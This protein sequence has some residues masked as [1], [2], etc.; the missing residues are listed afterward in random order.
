MTD[1]SDYSPYSVADDM[2]WAALK[3]TTTTY[4]AKLDTWRRQLNPR[5]NRGMDFDTAEMPDEPDERHSPAL[6]VLN[7]AIDEEDRTFSTVKRKYRLEIVG[8]IHVSK[9]LERRADRLIKRYQHLVELCLGEAHRELVLGNS[10]YL[11]TGET[12]PIESIDPGTPEFPDWR[13]DEAFPGFIFPI[14]VLLHLDS[15]WQA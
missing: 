6:F 3:D 12:N 14:D 15:I 4:G 5:S 10:V 7:G 11:P 2:I 1:V 9:K 8:L 13:D